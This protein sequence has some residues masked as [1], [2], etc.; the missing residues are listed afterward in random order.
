MFKTFLTASEL[1]FVFLCTGLAFEQHALPDGQAS[2]GGCVWERFSVSMAFCP[3]LK[4]EAILGWNAFGVL[5]K[6]ISPL[7]F[8]PVEMTVRCALK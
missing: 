6:K 1:G 4:V 7:R 3:P 8:A 5:L 2:D